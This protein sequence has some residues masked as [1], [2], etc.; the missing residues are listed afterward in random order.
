MAYQEE[1]FLGS[2]D[3]NLDVYDSSGNRTG[4]LD[5][6]N[7]AVFTINPPTLEKKE[8]SGMRRENY[9]QTIKSVIT[10]QEQ[11]LKFTLT[12]IN[13]KN[14][15]L[16]MFGTDADYTQTAGNN[17]STPES[18]TAHHDKWT[19]LSNRNLDPATPPVVKDATD[20]TTYVEGTDYEI[21]YQVGRIKVLATGSIADG[22]TLHV[23]STWL[24]ISNGFKVQ[25]NKVSKI[26]C[27]IRLI[28]QDQANDR[29]CEVIVQKAQVEPSG[30][31]NWLTEDFAQL[32]FSGKILATND[33]T[34]DVFFY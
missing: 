27:F 7:A 13:R 4:E 29:D 34:W 6:G 18:V 14:L 23:G 15:A 32:E 8:R 12:D 25:G 1:S 16:A 28:G 19:K 21:D 3:L 5:V 24:A 33:G 20:T 10:K 11:E 31:I 9:A 17:T 2:G 22:D 26:E 30:D